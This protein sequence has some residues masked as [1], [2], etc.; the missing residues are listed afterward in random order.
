MVTGNVRL[1][2]C[3]C[4]LLNANAADV[5]PRADYEGKPVQRVR[6]DPPSQ[7]LAQ[8]DLS[9]LVNFPVGTPLTLDAVRDTIKRL[10]ASG[11][12]DNIEIDAEPMGA[13]VEV[14]VR[15]AEQWFVGP[16]EVRGKTATPP[17]AGQL[18]NATR[19]Q[20][21]AP[22]N[23]PD[24]QNAIN[25]MQRLLQRNGLYL[26][27][28]TPKIE[29]DAAHQQVSVTFQVDAG[30]RA[31]LTKPEIDGDTRIDKET[32]EK[33]A[34]YKGWF[35][36]KPATDDNVQRGVK[37]IDNKYGKQDRLTANVNL[38]H[39]DYEKADNRVKP[40]IHADGGPKV[41]IE[42]TGAKISKGNL[43]KYVPVFEEQTVNRDLLV[44]G[45]ANLRDYYQN[46]GYF[47]VSVDFRS[48]RTN[49]DQEIIT[50]VITPGDR[51]K[52]VR[53]AFQGNHYFRTKDI[54][55][56]LF[57]QAN[58]FIRLRRGRFSTGFA[59]K[60]KETIST[61]Y[62]S[63]G[64]QDVAVDVETQQDY[65]GKK[66]DVAV[67]FRITEG[68]QYKIAGVTIQGMTLPIQK[69]IQAQL[70]SIKG[71]PFSEAN[72]GMDR[73]FILIKYQTGGYPDAGFAWQQ[74]PGPEPNTVNLTYIISEGKPQ[75]VRDVLI[76][77]IRASRPRLYDPAIK[78]KAGDPLS[79]TAMGDMQR[80]LYDLGVFDKVDMAIQNPQGD[81]PDKYVVYHLTEGHKWY[82]AAGVGAELARFGGSQSDVGNS[83][84]ATGIAP[85][86]QLEVSRLNLWGLGHSL[87]F[88]GRYSTLDRRVQVNYLAPRFHNVAG[89]NI[90][91][92][93]L[94]DNERD[95]LTFTARRLEGSAQLS[96]K[97][98]KAVTAL[99][100]YTWRNVQVDQGSLKI[101]PL[102][103]PLASQP[104][105]LGIV[106]A[107][108]VQ[109]RRDDA[110]DAH[111]GIY[112][113][114]NVELVEHYFGGNKNFLRVLGRNSYY[115]TIKGN[116]VLASN[117][118]FGWIHPFSVPAGV[119]PL[120]YIPIPEHFF[121]GGADS[122]RAFP[123]N[124]AGP[125][126]PE[127]GFP[128]GGN[129]LFFHATEFRF[130]FI[131]DNIGGVLF[132]DM[133]NVFSN[134]GAIS[135]R[136]HQNSLTDFDYMVHAAGFGIRYKTPLGPIRV[137]LAYS[138]NPPRFNG[139]V[140][141]YQQ[142]LFGGAT[143]TVTAVSHFQFFISI[144]QA[145]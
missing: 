62:K 61:L 64:F 21:G 55:P 13:G 102:L 15:T 103:I 124:Q 33:A 24:L 32:L 90:S 77:G 139:L 49:P 42:T 134:L 69:E 51:H 132:E 72:V 52:L 116:Y 12:Y 66:G 118:E 9:K 44:R 122:S 60:D 93:A 79:W 54:E 74:T 99:F 56:L 22:Y 50:Y 4:L 25:G 57:L 129:A 40:V 84:G 109:D 45:A 115:K 137:D 39:L 35:R 73:S 20:L 82:T 17:N 91:V 46:Q 2:L 89:R 108:L 106:A 7:P 143:K 76:T 88:K 63:N 111:R 117:T 120:D 78:L 127:T 142:L 107:N 31:R 114:G 100:R 110:T 43:K 83:T 128:L 131:G 14:V 19:L 92:T 1:F 97:L 41:E 144:G 28:V 3:F 48:A 23:D 87:N 26:A 5:A 123:F 36:W 67:T 95:V 53:V 121:G 30:K 65:K 141:T 145:F 113:S 47:D 75:T 16:F 126:D 59:N 68:Q 70:T 85:R 38:D 27:S 80:N 86:V 6:F 29:R 94:Y 135:F 98:T 133:G 37:N 125:R 130:P 10:Y 34:K 119:T 58:G 104:A 18:T 105:R 138:I 8:T 140:G 11:G 96:E 71:E 112:N 136:T 81:V 101:N